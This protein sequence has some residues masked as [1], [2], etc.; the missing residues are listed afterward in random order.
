MSHIKTITPDNWNQPD[1]ASSVFT[2][3]DQETAQ[4]RYAVG[5]D[6]VKSIQAPSLAG[7]VPKDIVTLFEVARGTMCYGYFFYPL[8]SLGNEQ[9]FRVDEAAVSYVCK[10]SGIPEKLKYHEKLKQLRNRDFI[11][12][13]DFPRWEASRKLRN[14]FSHPSNQSLIMPAMAVDNVK[15]TAELINTLF[16]TARELSK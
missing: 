12:D 16:S 14:A 15:I 2:I 6:Y 11:S 1:L 10:K 5:S 9:L 8:F 3:T 13:C 7:Y 4:Q